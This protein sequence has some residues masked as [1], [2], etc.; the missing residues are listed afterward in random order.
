MLSSVLIRA[1][2]TLLIVSNVFAP[3][4][5]SAD[6]DLAGRVGRLERML[7]NQSGSDLLLQMQR[8]QSEMQELRGMVEQQRFDVERLQRQQRDQF[9]DL[10]SR[11]SG[12]GSAPTAPAATALPTILDESTEITAPS[13]PVTPSVPAAG[14]NGIPA[15]PTPEIVGA[16]ERDLYAQAFEQLKARNYPEA[17][18]ALNALLTRYPQGDYTDNA[19]YWLGETYYVLRDYP[20]ALDEY[21]RLIQLHP[22]SAK[23]PGALL[24]IGFIQYEQQALEQ[25]RATLQRV[26]QDYPNSTEA[27]LAQGRLERGTTGAATP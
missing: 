19:R 2:P 9:L 22:T 7:E 20:A 17:K 27:R 4:L 18:T 11:L 1:L 3:S 10:D 21:E 12:S 24:K 14:G 16:S 15:L 8:L 26:I 23:V 6:S 13:T 5:A 25:A